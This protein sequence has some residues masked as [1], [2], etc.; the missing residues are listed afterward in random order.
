MIQTGNISITKLDAA[1]RQIDAAVRLSFDDDDKIAIHTLTWA[2]YGILVAYDIKTNSG[3]A[4]G[5]TLRASPDNEARIISNFLKHA[6]KDHEKALY[7]FPISIPQTV[8]RF[9]IKLYH[10]LTNTMS[11]EMRIFS[12]AMIVIDE[13]EE[14]VEKSRWRD[15]YYND[16]C[17]L[18]GLWRSSLLRSCKNFLLACKNST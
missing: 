3:T 6:D 8:L 14:D 4:W 5:S 15:H 17:Q 1:R 7:D 9:S 13:M 12:A 2:A 18:D 11:E 16:E 10:E